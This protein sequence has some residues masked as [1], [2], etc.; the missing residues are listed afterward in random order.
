MDTR[1]HC[2]PQSPLQVLRVHFTYERLLLHITN[3]VFSHSLVC[4]RNCWGYMLIIC[5]HSSMKSLALY[6]LMGNIATIL[7]LYQ[8]IT[9]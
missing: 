6:F 3:H 7:S 1:A 2:M 4:Y 9:T 5:S 8:V